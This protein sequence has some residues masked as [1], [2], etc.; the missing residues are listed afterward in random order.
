MR[1]PPLPTPPPQKTPYYIP[2]TPP[3]PRKI[4]PYDPTKRY[5]PEIIPPAKETTPK[6]YAD[7]DF[8][9]VGIPETIQE[10]TRDPYV[11]HE[12]LLETEVTPEMTSPV[13]FA[14]TTTEAETTTEWETTV[15]V[16]TAAPT[17]PPSGETENILLVF[18]R[19]PG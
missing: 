7:K 9:K 1:P 4:V 12:K 5:T 19:F 14:M 18:L 13:N 3:P 10:P 6:L 17:A 2:H 8:T 15:M 11:P 16:T